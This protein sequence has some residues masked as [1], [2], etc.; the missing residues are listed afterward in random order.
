MM[1]DHQDHHSQIMLIFKFLHRAK[2]GHA[3][4][5]IQLFTQI[6]MLKILVMK[7]KQAFSHGLRPLKP[8]VY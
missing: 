1:K 6:V 3:Y 7:K 2:G 5:S 8:T 4:F